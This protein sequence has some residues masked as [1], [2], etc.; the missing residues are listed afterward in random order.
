MV[1]VTL[2]YLLEEKFKLSAECHNAAVAAFKSGETI[3][4]KEG[5]KRISKALRE[6]IQSRGEFTHQWRRSHEIINQYSTMELAHSLGGMPKDFK[7]KRAYGWSRLLIL[8]EMKRAIAAVE[9]ILLEAI[10]SYKRNL[11]PTST[12]ITAALK[13]MEHSKA[14]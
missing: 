8:I 7:V 10:E 4:I 9:D 12:R 5:V 14:S 2:C 1:F 3:N 6:H 11:L 13:R